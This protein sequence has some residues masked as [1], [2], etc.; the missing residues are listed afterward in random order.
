MN[1]FDIAI[2]A[3]ASCPVT[4]IAAVFPVNLFSIPLP[5][6]F[7]SAVRTMYFMCFLFSSLSFGVS[8]FAGCK[9]PSRLMHLSMNVFISVDMLKLFIGVAKIIASASST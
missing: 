2:D 5:G 3:P 9:L 6:M 8:G 1:R 4:I 7:S